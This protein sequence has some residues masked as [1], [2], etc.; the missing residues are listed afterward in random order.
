MPSAVIGHEL[1]RL[2]GLGAAGA[3]SDE[4]LLDV[5]LGADERTAAIAFEAIV[6]R[7]GPRV[8]QTCRGVLREFHAAE[9]AFQATFLVLARRAH[10]LGSPDLLGNWLQGVAIRTSKKAKALIARQRRHEHEFAIERLSAADGPARAPL[11]GEHVVLHE[12]IDR[13]PRSY[14]SAIALCY[15]EGKSHAEAAAQLG[16]SESTVRGR[17]ARARKLLDRRLVVRDAAPAFTL[18]G[19][20]GLDIQG[21]VLPPGAIQATARAALCFLNRCQADPGAVTART[22][23]LANGELSTMWVYRIKTIAAGIVAIGGL[24]A[25][26]LVFTQAA[27]KAQPKNGD[28]MSNQEVTGPVERAGAIEG[29]GTNVERTEESG[30]GDA[31]GESASIDPDLAKVAAGSIV[32]TVPISK[33]SM[34]LSYLPDWDHGD[35]DNI[36][37]GNNDGGN[38]MLMDWLTAIPADEAMLPDY[39]FVI[40]V[41]S[42]ETVAHPPAGPIM[43]FELTESW[44]ERASW[45][46]RPSYNPEPFSTYSFEPGK[47]WKLFDVTS[48]VRAQAKAGRKGFGVMIR[49]VSE[50]LKGGTHSDYKCVSREATGEWQTRRPVLL[51]VKAGNS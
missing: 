45:K 33:D 32:R 41:Y 51:V 20:C 10:T 42:R 30:A 22:R 21:G 9:D 3:L 8:L 19:L 11:E 4:Q 37:I 18:P 7:H 46:S 35:V 49:F 23:A 34:V 48:L 40:A 50:D 13:L 14:R 2:F 29:V 47:G 38:R 27:A 17:L 26:S 15:L 28:P 5:F 12:E 43:G 24:T 25:A 36:G 1:D 44:Q 16:T 39:R 6:E 31:Q